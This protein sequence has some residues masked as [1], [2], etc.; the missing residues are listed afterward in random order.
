MFWEPTM[1]AL[2]E[3]EVRQFF[4]RKE[5]N[6]LQSMN[7]S[8]LETTCKVTLDPVACPSP[9]IVPPASRLRSTLVYEWIA[10]NGRGAVDVLDEQDFVADLVIEEL[11]DSASG[12]E[13]TEAAG[14]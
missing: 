2:T 1:T 10:L 5:W 3:E 11:V 12:E 14:W 9:D 7:P 6:T 4:A 13:E 8:R